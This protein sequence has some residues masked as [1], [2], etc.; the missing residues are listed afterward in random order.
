MR[1]KAVPPTNELFDSHRR[2]MDACNAKRCCWSA[3][4]VFAEPSSWPRALANRQ[5]SCPAG[6]RFPSACPPLCSTPP[7]IPPAR[8]TESM[9]CHTAPDRALP[10]ASAPA[11]LFALL[12]QS[13]S[14]SSCRAS[15]GPEVLQPILAHAIPQRGLEARP[16]AL[17]V[18]PAQIRH[19]DALAQR[20]KAY[21]GLQQRNRITLPGAPAL[22][23]KSGL[24]ARRI[25]ALATLVRPHPALVNSKAASP[26]EPSSAPRRNQRWAKGL[27]PCGF[28]SSL[29]KGVLSHSG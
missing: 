20:G 29:T 15:H 16:A 13:A 11:Q 19:D 25:G 24:C 3:T 17:P 22:M 8:W 12:G 21:R 14:D 5:L 10:Q 23:Q 18:L 6:Y 26:R 28:E 27:S 7:R 4:H 9:C 2:S 1:A